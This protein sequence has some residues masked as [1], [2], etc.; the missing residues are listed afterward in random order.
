M[1]PF[2]LATLLK[3]NEQARDQRQRMLAD[4]Q[5]AVALL[6]NRIEQI[7]SDLENVKQQTTDIVQQTTINPDAWAD[8]QRYRFLLQSQKAQLVDQ[9]GQFE[10]EVE[11]RQ[12]ALM[13]ADQEVK[14]LEKM[15]DREIEKELVEFNLREQKELDDLVPWKVFSQKQ[16][17]EF[18]TMDGP[19]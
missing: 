17:S 10:Q 8:Q 14:K 5:Q 6:E 9:K 16:S 4:A 7:E 2:R 11:R 18:E 3:L 1:K 19:S 13:A 15:R 12:N